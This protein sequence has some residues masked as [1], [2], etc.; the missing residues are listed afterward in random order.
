MLF[1]SLKTVYL[2]QNYRWQGNTAAEFES[3]LAWRIEQGA[4]IESI[5]GQYLND[6]RYNFEREWGSFGS[7]LENRYGIRVNVEPL[8]FGS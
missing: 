2:R 8:A 5:E 4:P 7:E 1:P 3:Y 6:A